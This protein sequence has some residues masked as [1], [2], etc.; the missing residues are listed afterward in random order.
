VR[1][2]RYCTSVEDFHRE[3][4]YLEATCLT[5]GYTL[6]FVE[7]RIQAFFTRFDVAT[8]R[9]ILDPH[10]YRQLRHRLFNFMS[11]QQRAAD[12]NEELEKHDRIARLSYRYEYGQRHAFDRQLRDILSKHLDVPDQPAQYKMKL[13]VTTKQHYSLNGLLSAQKPSTR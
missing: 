5:N 2:V 9:L 8:L 6:A 12:K 13:V 3:R 11:E 4:V 10:V 7:E 1:A